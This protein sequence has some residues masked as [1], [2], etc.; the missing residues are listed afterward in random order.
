MLLTLPTQFIL[1]LWKNR[2]GTRLSDFLISRIFDLRAKWI[3]YPSLDSGMGSTNLLRPPGNQTGPN[4]RSAGRNIPLCLFVYLNATY[5][6]P[7]LRTRPSFS[8][9]HS[10][11]TF[12]MSCIAGRPQLKSFMTFWQSWRFTR[13]SSP[14]IVPIP[15]ERQTWCVLIQ[16]IFWIHEEKL[17]PWYG[18]KVPEH[19]CSRESPSTIRSQPSSG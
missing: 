11:L 19:E 5:Q 3:S 9:V 4:K 12:S 15:A 10:I 18:H 7:P 1:S 16:H 6:I 14:F 13:H 2:R 17:Q 8:H